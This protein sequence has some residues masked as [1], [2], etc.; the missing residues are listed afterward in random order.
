MEVEFELAIRP[1]DPEFEAAPGAPPPRSPPQPAMS[2]PLTSAQKR[3][4]GRIQNTLMSRRWRFKALR[5]NPVQAEHRK[6]A[7]QVDGAIVPRNQSRVIAKT[8]GLLCS[9]LGLVLSALA[10]IP[11]TGAVVSDPIHQGGVEAHV[12][13]GLFRFQPFVPEN[14]FP[15]GEK[16]PIQ[17]RIVQQRLRLALGFD[18]IYHTNEKN[19]RE[20]ILPQACPE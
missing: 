1:D 16:F 8:G 11:P 13:T 18:V 9:G 19:S 2:A 20:H 12:K 14:L 15:L 7:A 17:R 10:R 4:R 3:N 6:I 5:A